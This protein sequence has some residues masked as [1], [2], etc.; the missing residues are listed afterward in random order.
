MEYMNALV[1]PVR[2]RASV[3]GNVYIDEDAGA[4][5]AHL[6]VRVRGGAVVFSMAGK[7]VCLGIKLVYF[8]SLCSGELRELVGK[9]ACDASGAVDSR[10]GKDS[11]FIGVI[12]ETK[13]QSNL[14]DWR[15]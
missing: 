3:L 5:I 12:S 14:T 1:V 10:R 7:L 13:E 2:E 11:A 9:K 4:D 8:G 6:A 15:V